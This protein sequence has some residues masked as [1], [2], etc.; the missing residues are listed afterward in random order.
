MA[1]SMRAVAY[2]KPGP[3][4]DPA[5]LQDVELPVPRPGPRDL[6]VRVEAVSENP[7]DVKLRAGSDPGGQPRVLGFDAA[8]VVTAIGG[9]VSMFATGDEVFYAGSADRPGSNAQFQVVDE[10]I[11]GQKPRSLSFA[12]A[13]ALP[14]T[15]LTAWET[16]FDRFR[17]DAAR[18]GTLLVLGAAGGVGSMVVQ[19]ARTLTGLTVIG[20]ASRPESR[21]WALG[22]GA[23]H[24]VDHHDL[25]PAVRAIAPDGVGY[26][27]SAHT[28]GMI[29]AFAE[30]LGP[31]GEVTAID[32]P[33]GLDILPLKDKSITFHWEFVF[34]RPLF[35][36]ADMAAQHDALE[37]IARLV[38]GGSLRTTLTAE[39]GP[40]TA[41]TLRRA[42]AMVEDG[43]MTGKVV[44]A[45]F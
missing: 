20:T 37:Q 5:S 10:R 44:V 36:T 11:A 6:L 25:V 38:D 28:A 41:G 4:S 32:E 33:E 17:L 40:I 27:F 12:Q 15:G 26:V 16:L 7:V 42:H 45:G 39:L 1:N 22:L 8:G 34:T 30:L 35:Q 29:G 3:V 23:H 18:R 14:L 21:Q 2:R 13:A 31:A 19:L 24:V 9:G 43:H